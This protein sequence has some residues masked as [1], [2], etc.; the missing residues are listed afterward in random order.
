M[1]K[2]DA[3]RRREHE[4][5]RNHVGIADF[6][7]GVLEISGKDA[8]DF[9]NEMCV[10][11]IK[12]AAPGRILY[13]SLLN[14]SSHMIDDVTVY[15]FA[16]DKFWMITAY[17]PE[18]MEWLQQHRRKRAVGFKDLSDT[19]VFWTIQGPES[20]RL[21]ASCLR[22]DMT[23]LKYYSFMKNEVSGIP[24]FVSRTGFTGELGYEIFS[25]RRQ[26]DFIVACLLKGGEPYGIRILETDVTLESLPTEKGLVVSRDFRGANPLELGMDG[27]VKFDKPYF[28]GKEALLKVREEG[29]SR[30]LMGFIA[31]NEEVD[32]ELESQVKADGQVIGRVTTANYGYTVE[33]SIGYCM[34]DAKYASPGQKIVICSDGEELQATIADRVFYD[35]ERKRIRADETSGRFPL[36]GPESEDYLGGFRQNELKGIYAAMPTPMNGDESLHTEGIRKL[37]NHLVAGGVDG[38]LAG[39]NSGEYP[40]LTLEERKHLF[41]TTIDEAAGRV[42]I[43]C[44][45]SA[46]TTAWAKELIGYAGEI[47][48]DFVLV[49]PPFDMPTTQEGIV[50]Y[51][52]ELADCSTAG[53]VIYHYP[54]YNQITIPTEDIRELARHPK[55]VGIKNVDEITA[56]TGIVHATCHDSFGVLTGTEQCFLPLLAV[57]GDGFMGVCASVAPQL[58]RKIYDSFLAGDMTAAA[59]ANRKWCK[60]ADLVFSAPFTAGLKAAMEVQGLPCGNPRKPLAAA[61]RVYRRQIHSL[62]VETGVIQ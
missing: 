12:K 3:A 20:R 32:I 36:T 38:I 52:R 42:K 35:P 48:A 39:G 41:K 21:L 11:D 8:A 43:A 1:K 58:A 25:E 51:Y 61:D 2:Y 30:R 23:Q 62:L 28:V 57:G 56:T 24:V 59:E 14:E 13:T 7:M 33:K 47:G 22:Y 53:V 44:C 34:V 37:V 19:V 31:E 45:C 26:M 27:L 40:M 16:A 46:N 18:T 6:T 54:A 55:I 9:L 60:V 50:D 15:S 5:V 17:L 49:S 29:V 4:L 10:N